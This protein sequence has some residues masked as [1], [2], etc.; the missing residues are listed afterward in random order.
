MQADPFGTPNQK[1]LAALKVMQL[2]ET[3]AAV[4]K[5]ADPKAYAQLLNAIEE[6]EK[7]PDAPTTTDLGTMEAINL[8]NYLLTG[9][10]LHE[11]EGFKFL[12]KGE[13]PIDLRLRTFTDKSRVF[14]ITIVEEVEQ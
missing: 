12:I 3:T 11:M 14:R 5:M 4:L 7:V 9:G 8:R 10:S 2:C 6:A 13:C 1:M